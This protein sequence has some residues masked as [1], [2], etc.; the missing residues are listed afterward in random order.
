MRPRWRKVLGW[1][2]VLNFLMF[3][4]EFGASR[5]AT[6]MS[7]QADSLDFLGDSFNY[8]VSLWVASE[9][10]RHRAWVSFIKGL[11]MGV[12][13]LFILFQTTRL[14]S[15]GRVPHP[16][17]MGVVG[18]MGFAVNF[19]VA[20]LLY[21]F[22]NGD[23]NM[24][25]VWLCTRNDAI[26]NFLVIVTG[27]IVHFTHSGWPDWIT[28]LLLATLALQSGIRVM[29]LSVSEMAISAEGSGSDENAKRS[30]GTT[31][32]QGPPDR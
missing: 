14:V 22:R 28:G 24:Q 27:G 5:R 26:G 30:P 3:C 2:L 17:T 9:A 16:E 10:L 21:R 4:I 11:S 23:S 7:L 32:P 8:A 13:G 1:A 15:E 6:S 20:I 31:S 12:F 18:A 25:S 29:R 19:F